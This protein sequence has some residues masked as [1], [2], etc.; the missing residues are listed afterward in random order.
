MAKYYSVTA[1]SGHNTVSAARKS[2]A[3]NL[4]KG[5]CMASN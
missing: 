3:L 1:G 5:R 2:L 4:D